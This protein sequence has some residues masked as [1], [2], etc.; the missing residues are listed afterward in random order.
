MI[1]DTV[2]V[3]GSSGFIAS[4]LLKGLKYAPNELIEV[5]KDND[6]DPVDIRNYSE[7]EEK[8][9][10][11]AFCV[12]LAAEADVNCEYVDAMK[13]NVDG[14]ENVLK[15][16]LNYDIPMI[17][18]S[19][20]AAKYPESHAYAASKKRQEDK[21]INSP[22]RSMTI[23]LPNVVGP[24]HMKGN[25]RAMIEDALDESCVYAWY[26]GRGVRTYVSRTAVCELIKTM[27][28]ADNFVAMK[29]AFE[30][31]S[32]D[33]DILE[34]QGI[35]MMTYT[36]GK[37]VAEEVSELSESSV[38]C[39]PIDKEAG[40]P[41]VLTTEGIPSWDYYSRPIQAIKEQVRD[42]MLSHSLD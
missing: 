28:T 23:R 37:I 3:T 6:D 2:I 33:E 22:V 9:E 40:S 31:Y 41:R 11:N 30:V 1:R 13:T 36:V 29:N 7:L 19:S 25:V 20:V 18:I 24:G 5:D 4:E 16:C 17:N 26:S 42:E 8:F 35:D 38:L 34:F 32:N 10:D 21:V 15:A 12:H 27:I 14:T 39:E